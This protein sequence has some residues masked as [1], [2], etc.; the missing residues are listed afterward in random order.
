VEIVTR[1]FF[2]VVL[3]ATAACA[4]T[5]KCAPAAN[6]QA[7]NTQANDEPGCEDSIRQASGNI[8]ALAAPAE[9]AEAV[10]ACI[11][12]RWSVE[13]R[14]CV[15]AARARPDLAAC[16]TRQEAQG[17]ARDLRVHGIE[18][19]LG[20]VDGGTYVVLKG[21]RFL[22]DGPRNVKIYFGS[23]QGTVVRVASDSQLIVQA[24]GGK[25][26]EVVDVIVIFEPGGTLKLP[27]AFTFVEKTSAPTV[28]ELE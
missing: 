15:A 22:A 1:A 25:P 19:D 26:D 20:D 8:P 5:T 13:S 2:L 28:N 7:K 4:G 17:G 23:R 6:T 10:S 9:M 3:L 27:G 12:D 14:R 24:P 18:P 21:S 11:R 16:M